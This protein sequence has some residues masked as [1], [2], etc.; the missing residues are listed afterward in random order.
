MK[1]IRN[2][3]I[4]SLLR[5]LL[6]FFIT[7]IAFFIMIYLDIKRDNNIPYG[8]LIVG[9]LYV[10]VSVF[11]VHLQYL[12]YNSNSFFDLIDENHI[13][14]FDK[15]GNSREIKYEDVFLVEKNMTYTYASGGKYFL[16]SDTYHYSKI[17]LKSGDSVIIT[18]LLFCEFDLFSE[19]T[20][21]KKKLIAIII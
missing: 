4:K 6:S 17:L 12:Y 8:F 13:V 2:I 21:I 14:Y 11:I 5:H 9:I 19:K 7:I 3:T 16:P 1:N 20:K 10:F 15:S 18:S